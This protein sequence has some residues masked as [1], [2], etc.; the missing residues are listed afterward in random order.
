MDLYVP[1]VQWCAHGV[2]GQYS[3]L[4][5]EHSVGGVETFIS[6]VSDC[7]S[8]GSSGGSGSSSGS[9]SEGSGTGSSGDTGGVS[10]DSDSDSGSDSGS[11]SGY[12]WQCWPQWHDEAAAEDEAI[13]EQLPRG[14][15][16]AALDIPDRSKASIAARAS[17]LRGEDKTAVA[18]RGYGGGGGS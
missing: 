4:I 18:R 15:R 12:H 13:R 16:L 7:S 10:S 2:A 6:W 8:G 9:D 5:G 3:S 14:V 1:S 11:G 17:K